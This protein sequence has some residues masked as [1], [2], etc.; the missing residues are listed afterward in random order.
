MALAGTVAVWLGVRVGVDVR[1]KVAVGRGP[2]RICASSVTQGGEL[3]SCS[4][5]QPF[6]D[7][8]GVHPS[9][10]NATGERPFCS[11]SKRMFTRVRLVPP[12]G[13]RQETVK[14]SRPAL[15]LFATTR[16]PACATSG[17]ALTPLLGTLILVPSNVRPK[18]KPTSCPG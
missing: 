3:P 12:R 7:S 1:L 9:G 11:A 17:P 2:T 8:G 6:G 18:L 15:W 4:R 14:Q 5:R 10:E 13:W 16:Q